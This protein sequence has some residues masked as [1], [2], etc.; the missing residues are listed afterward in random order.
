[1]QGLN[2]KTAELTRHATPKMC[3]NQ[4]LQKSNLEVPQRKNQSTTLRRARRDDRNGY[5]IFHIQ[6]PESED[7]RRREGF[8]KTGITPSS[9]LRFM[10]FNTFWKRHDDMHAPV[11]GEP[12]W[13]P[14]WTDRP[15]NGADRSPSCAATVHLLEA[16]STA[17]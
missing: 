5:I 9:G 8:G 16:S 10:R 3:P 12:K 4:L 17:S 14:S 15:N 6:S 13:G 11:K 2:R 7:I 1:L